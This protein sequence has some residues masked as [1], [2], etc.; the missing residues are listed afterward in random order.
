MRD[1]FVVLMTTATSLNAST[2]ELATGLAAQNNAVL[3]FFHVVPMTFD[4]GESMLHTSVALRDAPPK[5]WLSALRPSDAAVP[6]RHRYEV[7]DPLT[8]IERFVAEHHV[9]FV[10]A[11]EPPRMWISELLWRGFAERLVRRIDCPVVIGGPA[12]LRAKRRVQ[13]PRPVWSDDASVAELLNSTVEAR[14]HALRGWMRRAA[15]AVEDIA[16]SDSVQA[17]VA[18]VDALQRPAPPTLERRMLVELEEH[19]RALEAVSWQL[20]VGEQ[21]WGSD[22]SLDEADPT[23]ASCLARAKA[24]GASCTLPM[25]GSQDEEGLWILAVAAVDERGLLVF[26]FDAESDFLRILGQPGPLPSFETYAFDPLGLMLSR[27]RFPGHLVSAGLLASEGQQAPLNVRVAEPS[28]GPKE[29]WPLTLMAQ[30]A[31]DSHD[32]FDTRGYLDYRGVR[33]V[34]AWRWISEFGFGVA[35]EVDH[36]AVYPVH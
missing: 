20:R 28:T 4:Q 10:V 23:F 25:A 13:A 31:T 3:L 2:L 17:F 27:T 18:L 1:K 11:E 29:Q 15:S 34:G 16:Y 19:R 7:G 26:R 36:A 33:V 6:H 32:G 22:W 5:R 14:S 35:A 8:I 24:D 9:E 12:F 21:V 30:E